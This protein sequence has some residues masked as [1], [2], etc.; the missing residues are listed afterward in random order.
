MYMRTGSSRISSRESSSSSGSGCLVVRW[1]SAWS[2]ISTSRLRSFEN[3][4][5]K[6]S[7]FR[8]EIEQV[9]E[10]L[11]ATVEALEATLRRR[12][13]VQTEAVRGSEPPGQREESRATNLRSSEQAPLAALQCNEDRALV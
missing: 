11:M 6:S 4:V 10:K 13:I 1:T 3:K 5:S 8:H 9:Q 7:G 2:T 12:E